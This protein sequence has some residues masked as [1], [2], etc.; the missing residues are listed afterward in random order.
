MFEATE[1]V[2]RIMQQWNNLYKVQNIDNIM[3]IESSTDVKRLR[4]NFSRTTG[5][6]QQVQQLRNYMRKA[7]GIEQMKSLNHMSRTIETMLQDFSGNFAQVL[8]DTFLNSIN[9]VQF[10]DKE[11]LLNSFRSVLESYAVDKDV[12]QK[13]KQLYDSLFTVNEECY[14]S[15]LKGTNYTKED[16]NEEEGDAFKRCIK[17]IRYIL[18]LIEI[19]LSIYGF[20]QFSD[21]CI[22]PLCENAIVKMEGNSSI[23]IIKTE[24]AKIYSNPS[25]RPMADGGSAVIG[26]AYYGEQVEILKEIKMWRE[27]SYT[28]CSGKIIIGWI[29]KRNLLPYEEYQFHSDDL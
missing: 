9:S 7:F 15:L 17:Y 26:Y 16:I 4:E 1:Q 20:C 25:S 14:E 27:V 10:G 11:K 18:N 3:K 28:D 22:R 21:N 23:Y 12:L 29:A 13:W 2:Q 19:I 6:I 24:K 8:S 5:S